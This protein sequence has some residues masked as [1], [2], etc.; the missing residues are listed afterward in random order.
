LLLADGSGRGV[1]PDLDV[2]GGS[3]DCFRNGCGVSAGLAAADLSGS[4]VFGFG[5]GDINHQLEDMCI[6]LFLNICKLPEIDTE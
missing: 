2:S 1:L 6:K 5:S 4:G 3:G